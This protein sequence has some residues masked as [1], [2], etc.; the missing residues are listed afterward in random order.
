MN[1]SFDIWVEGLEGSGRR[2]RRERRK[3]EERGN[4]GVRVGDRDRK[5]E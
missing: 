1:S 4:E 2:E 5:R 3:E